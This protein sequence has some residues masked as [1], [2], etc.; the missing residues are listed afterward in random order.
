MTLLMEPPMPRRNVLREEPP[1]GTVLAE[2]LIR[3]G[4][5]E[6]VVKTTEIARIVSEKTGRPM[7]RQRVANLL[8]AINISAETIKTLAAGLGVD[9]SEL[10]KRPTKKGGTSAN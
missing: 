8:N 3:L 1:D 7:S 9:P 2:N 4:Y 10:T 5:A 6:T